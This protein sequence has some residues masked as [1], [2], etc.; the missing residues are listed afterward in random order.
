LNN[1][2][3]LSIHDVKNNKVLK[4]NLLNLKVFSTTVLPPNPH[5][6]IKAELFPPNPQR[7]RLDLTHEHA[8]MCIYIQKNCINYLKK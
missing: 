2:S 4:I 6:G 3:Y 1:D 8:R 5:R 7:G